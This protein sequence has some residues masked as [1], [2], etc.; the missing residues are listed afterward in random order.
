M[1]E[2]AKASLLE[3]GLARTGLFEI[4]QKLADARYAVGK[5]LKEDT[6]MKELFEQIEVAEK[7]AKELRKGE[8]KG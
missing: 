1:V 6:T 8:K 3:S 4:E 7:T 5:L 2:R